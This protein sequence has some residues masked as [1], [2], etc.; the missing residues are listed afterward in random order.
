MLLQ[1]GQYLCVSMY[2]L[3]DYTLY[4]R[5]HALGTKMNDFEFDL[6]WSFSRSDINAQF[7]LR[8]INAF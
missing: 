8:F 4:I 2:T 3:A 6:S 1:T 5:Q 7:E